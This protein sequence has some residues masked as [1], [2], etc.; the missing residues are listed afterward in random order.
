[1]LSNILQSTLQKIKYTRESKVEVRR[2]L[3]RFFF[4]FFFL[5]SA[6]RGNSHQADPFD[7]P[8]C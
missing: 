7:I 3:L 8:S 6:D 1:M 4:S 2:I 5:E